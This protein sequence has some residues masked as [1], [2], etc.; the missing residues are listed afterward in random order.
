MI[1]VMVLKNRIIDIRNDYE[2]VPEGGSASM[3]AAAALKNKIIKV[4]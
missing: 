4:K 1:A 2:D 3:A